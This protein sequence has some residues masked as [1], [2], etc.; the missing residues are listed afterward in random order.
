MKD[1]IELLEVCRGTFPG[2]QA[3]E[4]ELATWLRGI[5]K[6]AGFFAE[7]D[8]AQAAEFT[9]RL[10]TEA[11]GYAHTILNEGVKTAL[12]ATFQ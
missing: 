7:S 1:D 9:E 6:E 12:K 2:A 11:A 10:A 5:I 8:P 3:S 4:A